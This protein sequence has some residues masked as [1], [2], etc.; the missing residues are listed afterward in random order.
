LKTFAIPEANELSMNFYRTEKVSCGLQLGHFICL[1]FE[2]KT[3]EKSFFN[4]KYINLSFNHT[5]FFLAVVK[6]FFLV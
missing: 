6:T 3:E 5:H 2:Y 4:I 1:S